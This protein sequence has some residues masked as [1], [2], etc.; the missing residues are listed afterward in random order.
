VNEALDFQK[1][2]SYHN[3]TE[4]TEGTG[5][6]EKNIYEWDLATNHCLFFLLFLD[7]YFIFNGFHI[8]FSFY[9][10][11]GFPSTYVRA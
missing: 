6:K 9:M 2:S 10:A 1:Q 5:T 7:F 3:G 11:L 8:A 4:G